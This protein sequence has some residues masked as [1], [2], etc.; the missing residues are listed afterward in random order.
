MI[1][2]HKNYDFES[3]WQ[4]FM[5]VFFGI[6]ILEK[7]QTELILNLCIKIYLSI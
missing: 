4:Y 6:I 3:S 7:F 1:I 5:Q 2:K